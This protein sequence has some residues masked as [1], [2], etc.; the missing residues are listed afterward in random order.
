MA[1]EGVW[2]VVDGVVRLGLDAAICKGVPLI[3][4]ATTWSGWKG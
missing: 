4:K 3:F 2:D 1:S